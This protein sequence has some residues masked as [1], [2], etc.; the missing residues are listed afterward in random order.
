[1]NYRRIYIMIIT[2]AL[3]EQKLGKRRKGKGVYYENH[4]ILP[5]SIFPLWKDKSSNQVLLTARE[6][7]FC[8]QL[9]TKIY[10]VKGMVFALWRLSHSGKHFVSSRDYERLR[11][12]VSKASSDLNRGHKCPDELKKYFSELYSGA[13]NPMFGRSA[14]REMDEQRLL[15][16]KENMSKVLKTVE[17]TESWK[18]NIS[19][20][21]KGCSKTTEHIE[22]IRA[23]LRES[24]KSKEQIKRLANL[25]RGKEW[26]NNG[27]TNIL[28]FEC[29]DGFVKGKLQKK[30][31]D[32]TQKRANE[33]RSRFGKGKH[34]FNNGKENAFCYECPPGFV[35]G[36]ICKPYKEDKEVK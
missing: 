35:A 30:I 13:G 14:I 27:V 12:Q 23:S 24:E 6:H 11:S 34:W 20:S 5:K 22:H 7:Y 15:E 31:A 19:K 28:A 33:A 16:Y 21:L 25:H 32:E 36:R 2:K 3:N 17:K 4:H 9:L 18:N 10:P 8:H 26:F 1:M 29:P